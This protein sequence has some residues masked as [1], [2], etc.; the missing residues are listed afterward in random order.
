MK[1]VIH[2][3][4]GIGPIEFGMSRQQVRAAL[5]V[6][7]ESF[8]RTED[9]VAETDEFSN[10][11]I[12][13]EYDSEDLCVAVE[14]TDPGEPEFQGRNLLRLPYNEVKGWFESYEGEIDVDDSGLTS[15]RFGIGVYAPQSE[16]DPS[17]LAEAV[18]VF[19]ER[20]YD[21]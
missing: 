14:V 15:L 6:P 10:L 9:D 12:F 17:L 8:M 16:D 18:I 3:Y 21:E 4:K 2:P 11:G 5:G 7:V 19:K 13:V 20:Y 1:L